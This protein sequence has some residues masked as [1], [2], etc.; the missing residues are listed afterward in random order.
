MPTIVGSGDPDS[1]V[2]SRFKKDFGSDQNPFQNSV[3]NKECLVIIQNFNGRP[4]EAIV[5]FYHFLVEMY[6]VS[7]SPEPTMIGFHDLIGVG[8]GPISKKLVVKVW[9]F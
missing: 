7:E 8:I 5:R 4:F 1:T 6:C 3:E 9:I 2:E